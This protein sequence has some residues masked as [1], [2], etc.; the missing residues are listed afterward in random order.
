MDWAGEQV[1]LVTPRRSA[2]RAA[3]LLALM[4]CLFAHRVSADRVNSEFGA[5]PQKSPLGHLTRL[6]QQQS[7]GFRR[8]NLAN[9]RVRAKRWKE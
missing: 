6:P 1:E 8:T 5:P 9:L 3:Q 4:C 7:A 2:R